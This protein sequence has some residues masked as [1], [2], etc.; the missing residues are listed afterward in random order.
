[1]LEVKGADYIIWAH[2]PMN[3]DDLGVQTEGREIGMGGGKTTT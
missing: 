3:G 1:M 2:W